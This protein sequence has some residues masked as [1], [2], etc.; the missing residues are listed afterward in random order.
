MLFAR[1][2]LP[3]FDFGALGTIENEE[4]EK[5]H[6]YEPCTT[7]KQSPQ[8]RILALSSIR[9]MKEPD[10]CIDANAETPQIGGIPLEPIH[11]SEMG[12][13]SQFPR[14]AKNLT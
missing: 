14:R 3:T 10:R 13:R 5:R 6:T 12:K 9:G 7:K 11:D 1:D 4:W 8:F 2:S